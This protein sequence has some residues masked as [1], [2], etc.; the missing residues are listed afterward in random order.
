MKKDITP[1][2]FLFLLIFFLIQACVSL[3]TNEITAYPSITE[4]PTISNQP[5]FTPS[6]EPIIDSMPWYTPNPTL[7]P[8]DE[9]RMFELLHSKNCQLPCYLGIKPGSTTL[10]EAQ[11]ILRS[12]KA[13]QYG[14]LDGTFGY[15]MDIGDPET[16]SILPNHYALVYNLIKLELESPKGIV[17]SIYIS[18]LTERYKFPVS[19][20]TY[21]EYWSR[22]SASNI[23]SEIGKPDYLYLSVDYDKRYNSALVIVYESLGVIISIRGSWQENNICPIDEKQEIYVTMDLFDPS[24]NIMFQDVYPYFNS[25]TIKDVLGITIDEFYEKVLADPTICFEPKE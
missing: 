17:Q 21:R 25:P 23:F 12:L 4:S 20:E 9:V 18:I 6:S 3:G 19:P 22:Y 7:E 8:D 16:P 14:T 11:K 1:L 13:F 24:S 5:S 2:I 15:N 10:H